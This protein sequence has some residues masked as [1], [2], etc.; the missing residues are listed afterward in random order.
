[1]REVHALFDAQCPCLLTLYGAFL[2]REHEVVLVLEYMDGGSLENVVAQVGAMASERALAGVA[3][4]VLEALRY[5]QE[6]KKVVHRDIKPP[7]VLLNSRGQVKLS[8]FGIASQLG[9]S[10]AMCGTFV[11]SFRY[12][13][14]ER[15]QR[16]PYGFASDIWSFGLV[17]MEAA[18][19][20]YPYQPTP[21]TCIDMV[22]TLLEAPAPALSPRFFSRELCDFLG[23][24]LHKAPADRASA[25]QLLASPWLRRCG[26]TSACGVL[27]PIMAL[28]EDSWT[29]M[30]VCVCVSQASRRPWMAC[31]SGSRRCSSRERARTVD[32][33]AASSHCWWGSC[34]LY[35]PST[36]SSS[37]ERT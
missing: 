9:D 19:G 24:C 34:L 1:M 12:M 27:R 5:M 16:R 8:D 2:L 36:I 21:R 3:F 20:V 14:P 28:A 35:T 33:Q 26:V 32:L 29:C 6:R 22:Q 10:A 15:V 25:R 31:A 30:C 37:N 13:S 23:D 17:L 7:N 18:T 11:G 4:Q